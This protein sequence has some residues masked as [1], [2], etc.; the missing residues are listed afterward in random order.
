MQNLSLIKVIPG[1]TLY[2]Q[3]VFA[4]RSGYADYPEYSVRQQWPLRSS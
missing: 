4:D 3:Q 1:L 2:H